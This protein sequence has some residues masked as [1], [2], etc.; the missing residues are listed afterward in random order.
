[1]FQKLLFL[2]LAGAAGT[3]A[4]YWLGSLLQKNLTYHFHFGTAVVNILGCLLFG[5]IWAILDN[6]LTISPQFKAVIFIG[7]FGAF[8][9]FSSFAFETVKLINDLRWAHAF[10]NILLQNICG[11]AGI[12]LGLAIGKNF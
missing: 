2:A 10:G 4:R 8:T 7:F 6:K 12:I 11:V 9:T 3:L 1:M 5:L